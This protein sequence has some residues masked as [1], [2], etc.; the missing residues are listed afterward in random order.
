MAQSKTYHLQRH[1]SFVEIDPNYSYKQGQ[2]PFE[3]FFGYF[4]KL[5]FFLNKSTKGNLLF[6]SLSLS[7]SAEKNSHGCELQVH[8]LG[9]QKSTFSVTVNNVHVGSVSSNRAKS[10]FEFD[11][12]LLKGYGD[13]L[14]LLNVNL[15]YNEPL[16][17]NKTHIYL[18]RP[19]SFVVLDSS[20]LK[21]IKLEE[22]VVGIISN[23]ND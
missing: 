8:N 7:Q 19:D 3:S 12:A 4:S 18:I 15:N 5:D 22:D 10:K 9:Q 20:K 21:T 17:L 13:V 2:V 16:T 14:R 23:L 11:C 6:E 1:L